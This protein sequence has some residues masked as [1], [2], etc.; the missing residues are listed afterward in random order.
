MMAA[1]RQTVEEIQDD[2]LERQSNTLDSQFSHTPR[3][4][5]PVLSQ[6]TVIRK[7][8]FSSEF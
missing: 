5:L 3:E 2:E 6:G 8:L 1:H 7:C 4:K